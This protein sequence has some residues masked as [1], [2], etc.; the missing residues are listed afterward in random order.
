MEKKILGYVVL[1]GLLTRNEAHERFKYIEW[2]FWRFLKG[3]EEAMGEAEWL[4]NDYQGFIDYV[5]IY[6][7]T[8][9]GYGKVIYEND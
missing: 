5:K 6:E 4:K 7:V 1:A 2:T 3:K 9:Q 8:P